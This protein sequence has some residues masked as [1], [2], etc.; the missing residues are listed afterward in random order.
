MKSPGSDS[1]RR[2][3]GAELRCIGDPF[4]HI[5]ASD[6]SALQQINFFI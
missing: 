3:A 6:A 4:V 1:R 5:T 2:E